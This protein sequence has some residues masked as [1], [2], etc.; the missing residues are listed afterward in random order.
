MSEQ[1]DDPL[2]AL[3]TP[4]PDEAS[5][6]EENAWLRGQ[7]TRLEAT[8]ALLQSMHAMRMAE[9]NATTAALGELSFQVK[10]MSQSLEQ[11]LAIMHMNGLSAQKPGGMMS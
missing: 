3:V 6:E 5:V 7:V 8:V 10:L 4:E 1:P 11:L 9:T 2:A